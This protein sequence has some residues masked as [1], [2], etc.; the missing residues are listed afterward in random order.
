MEIFSDFFQE[1]KDIGL[2]AL[3]VAAIVKIV[4]SIAVAFAAEAFNWS[5]F[6]EMFRKDFAK[7]V[8]VTG[9]II[10]YPNDAANAVL[11]TSYIAYLGTRTFANVMALLPEIADVLPPEFS[12]PAMQGRP[13]ADTPPT[14]PTEGVVDSSTP[15]VVVSN[16]NEDEVK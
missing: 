5:E 3:Y 10:L 13:P 12:G 1:L 6:G 16:P 4:T 14:A 8:V 2:Y 7:L 11:V 15:V 9:L